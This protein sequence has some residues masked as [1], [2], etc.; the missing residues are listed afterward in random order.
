[1]SFLIRTDK[2]D[3]F[4]RLIRSD[5]IIKHPEA[6]AECFHAFPGIHSRIIGNDCSVIRDTYGG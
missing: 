5:L 3:I 2:Q 4:K 1:M 6:V